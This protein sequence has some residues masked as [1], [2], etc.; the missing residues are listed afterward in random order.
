MFASGSTTHSHGVDWLHGE[1]KHFVRG[2]TVDRPHVGCI[3]IELYEDEE[4]YNITSQW[5]LPTEHNVQYP[6]DIILETSSDVEECGTYQI[7]AEF[8]NATIA[9]D[10]RV[11]MVEN[12][13]P[14]VL[15]MFHLS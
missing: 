15:Y 14:G 6:V 7:P 12:L 3:E 4:V 13:T 10:V 8:Q 1:P 9:N 5:T 2:C 11:H